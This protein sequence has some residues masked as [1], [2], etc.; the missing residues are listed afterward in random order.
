MKE[1][2]ALL[3]GRGKKNKGGTS[4]GK[5]EML[6]FKRIGKPV[7]KRQVLE[8]HSLREEISSTTSPGVEIRLREGAMKKGTLLKVNESFEEVGDGLTDPK[9]G[10][11]LY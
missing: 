10:R 2:E 3:R 11:L 4:L 9:H 6:G 7:L 1:Y 8:E 5:K